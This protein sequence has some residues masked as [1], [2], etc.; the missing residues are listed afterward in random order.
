V[1]VILVF[2]K[3]DN[4]NAAEQEELVALM[5][6]Y[7]TIGYTCI[8]LSAKDG[9]GIPDLMPYIEGKV[10]LLS[11]HSGVG[12]STLLNRLVP[13]A[14]QRTAHISEMHHS[15]LHTTTLSEM[16]ALSSGGYLID[17]PGIKGF[18]TFDFREGEVGHYFP[19]MFRA[20]QDCR[21]RN[22]THRDEPDCVVLR[23]LHEGRI[24]PSRYA[25]YLSILSDI[26]A[27]RYR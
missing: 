24:A 13:E 12:K 4:L 10:C 5:A 27:T 22:C 23:A 3:V 17:T 20:S 11:G 2:N 25:S 1:P 6:L 7:R 16:F 15:G 9:T 14:K 18:G 8:P 21:F 19:E 26:T